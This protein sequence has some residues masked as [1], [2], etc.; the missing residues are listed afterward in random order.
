MGLKKQKLTRCHLPSA[1]GQNYGDTPMKRR[2][3]GVVGGD[4]SGPLLGA[5]GLVSCEYRWAV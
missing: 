2:D 3:H 5:I 4:G 1:N